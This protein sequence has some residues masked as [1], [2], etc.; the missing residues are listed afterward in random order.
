MEEDYSRGEAIKEQVIP[1]AVG[2][3]T[4]EAVDEVPYGFD[5]DEEGDED[6]HD[7]DDDEDDDGEEEDK[8]KG[9]GGKGKAPSAAAGGADQPQECKQQ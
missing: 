9:K 7:D 1:N 6:D 5:D 4:G 8:P 3:F 2:F